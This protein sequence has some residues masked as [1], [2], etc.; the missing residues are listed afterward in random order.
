MSSWRVKTAGRGA[1]RKQN[2]ARWYHYQAWPRSISAGLVYKWWYHWRPL[3]GA[4]LF[5]ALRSFFLFHSMFRVPLRIDY[6]AT[7]GSVRLVQQVFSK[8]TVNGWRR[9]CFSSLLSTPSLP[10][11]LKRMEDEACVFYFFIHSVFCLARIRRK[12]TMTLI[13]CMKETVNN[14]QTG[15]QSSWKKINK[16]ST[17]KLFCSFFYILNI[18]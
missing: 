5:L 9:S 16:S 12:W 14:S 7:G 11:G 15:C 1:N 4:L 10:L 18:A 13:H 3:E 17:T 2:R 8:K 6:K